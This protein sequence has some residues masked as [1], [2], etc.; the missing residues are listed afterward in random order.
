MLTNVESVSIEITWPVNESFGSA[1]SVI[2]ASRPGF[3][4]GASVSV[5][6]TLTSSTLMSVS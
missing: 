2:V 6:P 1:S 5:M 3:T 4:F